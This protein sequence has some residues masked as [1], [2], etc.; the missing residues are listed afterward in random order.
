MKI[1]KYRIFRLPGRKQAAT[2]AEEPTKLTIAEKKIKKKALLIG[3]QRVREDENEVVSPVSP[4]GRKSPVNGRSKKSKWRARRKQ[5]TRD[6]LK[7]PHRD[8]RAMQDLLVNI[9]VLIDD[10]HPFHKQPTRDNILQ[11]IDNLIRDAQENDRFFFHFSGHSDQEDTDDIEE[12]DRKNEFIVTSDGKRIKDDELRSNLAMPLPA[13]SSLI[14]VFDS[15][16]SGTLLDLKHFRCNRVYVPWLNKGYRR[17]NSLW[18]SNKRM[19]AKISSR[20]GPIARLN[21]Q[22]VKWA[23]TSIDGVLATPKDSVT[24]GVKATSV[25]SDHKHSLS[26]VTDNLPPPAPWLDSP[27]AE[28][29][30]C[31]SPVAMYCTGHCRENDLLTYEDAVQADVISISSSKDSQISWEAANGTSMTQA[32]V[33]ILNNNAHPTFHDLLTLVSH[34]IHSFY[35]DLHSRAREYKK[36]VQAAN[37]AK[38]KMGKKIKEGDL[39]EMNNFQN[40]QLSSDRPL[41]MSRH[42]YP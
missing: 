31:M 8:V 24:F 41:D 3:I 38:I 7:G 12:E 17:T 42:F 13:K 4:I 11:E 34:D 14:A 40:P 27:T 15:C 25:S 29:K 36:K 37:R 23:R 39:V 18:N 19:H 33:K 10:D 35:V 20:G 16:H 1:V 9:T 21:Q 2:Q 6:A 32:L 5:S 22:V 28:S 26:I 30:Q